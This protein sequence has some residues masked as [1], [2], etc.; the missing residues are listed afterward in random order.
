MRLDLQQPILIDLGAHGILRRFSVRPELSLSEPHV[1]QVLL[2]RCVH[3]ERLER[4][5]RKGTDAP[6]DHSGRPEEISGSPQV[7]HPPGD[8]YRVVGADGDAIT[9]KESRRAS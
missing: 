6:L 2:R 4:W 9:R 3:T 1:I 8:A 5:L 7:G